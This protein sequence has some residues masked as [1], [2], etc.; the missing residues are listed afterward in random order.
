[1]EVKVKSPLFSRTEQYL[2]EKF[3]WKVL[4]QLSIAIHVCHSSLD[5]CQVL[6]RDIKP[7]NVFLDENNNV[8]LGDFGLARVLDWDESHSN[9]IVGTPYYMSPVRPSLQSLYSAFYPLNLFTHSHYT[10]SLYFIW[11]FFV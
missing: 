10:N 1:M 11:I 9:T 7:A 8:K 3:I 6:H 2:E 5:R 4:Y